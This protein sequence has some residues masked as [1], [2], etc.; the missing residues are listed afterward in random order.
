MKFSKSKET[1]PLIDPTFFHLCY[2]YFSFFLPEKE[3]KKILE[4]K[5]D[6]GK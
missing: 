4:K 5:R 6:K 3:R 2:C 1:P